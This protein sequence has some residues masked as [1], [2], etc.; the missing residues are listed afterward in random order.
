MHRR[1]R[2][3]LH[4]NAV[5]RLA[6]M[7]HQQDLFEAASFI[8][9]LRKARR[10]VVLVESES[11][12]T[13]AWLI[14]DNLVVVPSIFLENQ[15]QPVP[16][17]R[18]YHQS[19]GSQPIEAHLVAT[20][21]AGQLAGLL[22]IERPIRDGALSLA[23]DTLR[24]GDSI[25]ALQH[26]A[27]RQQLS[28]SIGDFVGSEENQL[29]YTAATVPGSAGSPLLNAS[30]AVVG[31]HEGKW[32]RPQTE[33][34]RGVTVPAI[35]ES[36][37]NSPVWEEIMQFH[38]LIDA[39][40]LT[41]SIRRVQTDA[42]EAIVK[43]RAALLWQ[44]APSLFTRTER[45]WL[46]PLVMNLEAPQ[47]SLAAEERRRILTG[48]TSLSELREA[49]GQEPVEHPG[50]YAIDYLL[51]GPPYQLAEFPEPALPY[52]LQVV[53]WFDGL[54]VEIP[55]PREINLELEK[56]RIRSRLYA[57]AGPSFR[58]R[59]TELRK[60]SDWYATDTA[61]PLLLTGIGGVGKSALL[62]RF[63]TTLPT[64]TLLLWLDFDRPD[65]APDNAV[66]V[67]TLL[68]QQLQLQRPS[69]ITLRPDP[70]DWQPAAGQFAREMAAVLRPDE[71]PLL[72]LDGFEIA[73]YIADYNEIWKLLEMLLTAAPSLRVIISGRA[74]VPQLQ[75]RQ[76]PAQL[77]QL[78][79]MDPADVLSWLHE[80]GIRSEGLQQQVLRV[81]QGIPLLLKLLLPLLA[82]DSNLV[83][84]P[85]DLPEQLVQGV[86]YQ[87]ILH[88]LGDQALLPL[89]QDALV[90]RF[91][92]E[93]LLAEVLAERLPA[94]MSLG[95]AFSR[96]SRELSIVNE[97]PDSAGYALPQATGVPVLYIRPDVRRV[98]LWLLEARDPARV[99]LL[100]Q[101][102]ARWYQQQDQQSLVYT[103]EAVYH[104]LLAGE[105]A[106]ADHIWQDGCARLLQDSLPDFT[107]VTGS[108]PMR[109]RAYK[110]L[111]EHL[112][113]AARLEYSEQSQENKLLHDV[114]RM[115]TQGDTA[116]AFR[117]LR[118]RA[119][120]LPDSPL[121]IFDAWLASRDNLAQGRHLLGSLTTV[122]NVIDRDRAL[123]G[124]F[125]AS[126]AN[127]PKEA[128]RLLALLSNAPQLWDDSSNANLAR[129][130]VRAAQLRLATDIPAELMLS[131]QLATT[132]R[133]E[134]RRL[135]SAYLTAAD[136]VLPSL[137][138]QLQEH[139]VYE[140]FRSTQHLPLIGRQADTRPVLRAAPISMHPPVPAEVMERLCKLGEWRR[141]AGEAWLFP[142]TVWQELFTVDALRNPLAVAVIG[143]L[144]AFRG[145][146]ISCTAWQRQFPS[147]DHLVHYCIESLPS[148]PASQRPL[149]QAA[150]ALSVLEGE[151]TYF[152]RQDVDF[153]WLKRLL[154][155][156]PTEMPY[157]R[158]TEFLLPE[159][160]RL[161]VTHRR[162]P[163]LAALGLYLLGPGPLEIL[164]RQV[165]NLPAHLAL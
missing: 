113:R 140:S 74:D 54:I 164:C 155:I 53:R 146:P 85:A 149:R 73:Q 125:L 84:L 69:V 44:F 159:L 118:S 88:R 109:T 28:F 95:E 134:V 7:E 49:R 152:K 156:S 121:V 20:V 91:V 4:G 26:L 80:H 124:A 114:S 34:N 35:L 157:L 133:K 21:T 65:L 63:V 162:N 1:P 128:Y 87:R 61:G 105:L 27:E 18:C 101:K 132:E 97:E 111:Q 59:S 136:V 112:E 67:L 75:L 55:Q 56:R 60:L 126:Q 119:V 33:T 66:S 106:M 135:D 158:S 145:Q 46:Q 76:R 10:G 127:E 131:Q 77:L 25:I 79:A 19:N 163:E 154:A 42:Q 148:L 108:A 9:G 31:T 38:R 110:W 6:H 30:W 102:A 15:P 58:G 82:K 92:T 13:T 37:H 72:V 142:V 122:K 104:N 96:L 71:R 68:T 39:T 89:V 43:R 100:H 64:E 50:Q 2:A 165:L 8:S 14:T 23:T 57:I 161:A 139:F 81:S 70:K 62:A 160:K 137:S 151:L 138:W 93:E 94:G 5:I 32:I 51:K 123:L 11:N 116:L 47:W 83:T 48:A 98:V 147:L 117:Y 22:R 24:Q 3:T 120:R 86:L 130:A 115:I 78:R 36:L 40:R 143:T 107:F 103:A 52:L 16:T 141:H 153:G 150:T 90:L 99:R 29:E 12:R 144:T 45:K 41:E 129:L 17:Y